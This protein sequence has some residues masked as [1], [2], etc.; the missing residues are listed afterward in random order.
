MTSIYFIRHASHDL[1]GKVLC[2]R[3]AGVRLSREGRLEADLVA[4]HLAREAITALYVSP[5]DRA[6]ETA[7]PVADALK[8]RSRTAAALDE[9]DFGAWTGTPLADLRAEPGWAARGAD[10]AASRPPGGET[11]AEAQARIVGWIDDIVVRHPGEAIAAVSHG[12]I[13]KASVAAALDLDLANVDRFEVSPA[14]ITVLHAGPRSMRLIR[15]NV[16]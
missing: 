9:I 2:G 5:R 7:A 10:R 6:R 16:C 8:M 14:S 13:I 4:S 15:L 11:L 12:D 3:M 1:L